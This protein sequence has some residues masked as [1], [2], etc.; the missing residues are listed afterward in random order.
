MKSFQLI[1]ICGLLFGF[2]CQNPEKTNWK[3]ES[4]PFPG[5]LPASLPVLSASEDQLLLSFVSSVN[6]STSALFYSRWENESWSEP[7][8]ITQGQDWFVNWADFPALV[9]NKGNYLAHV[10]KKSSPATFSYDIQLQ[11]FSTADGKWTNQLPLHQDSTLTEHGFVTSIAY[12]DSSYLVTWLDGRNTSGGHDHSNHEAS[13]AMTIRAAEVNLQ[14]KVLWDELLDARTC[15]CCQTTAAMTA[16][17]PIILYRNRSDREIRDIAITR[18]VKGKWTEP[19]IIYP[20]GWEITGCPVNGPKVAAINQTVLAAWFTDVNQESAV[21][22]AFSETSGA[23]FFPP[24]VISIRD[25]LGR[26][27]VALL[28]EQE[29]LVSWMEMAGDSTFLMVQKINRAGDTFP[30]Q[31]VASMDPGRRSGFPQMEIYGNQVFFAWTI[32]GDQPTIG[33]SAVPIDNF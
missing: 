25:A 28:N 10:L 24:Q 13:G 33:I 8:M 1:A 11:A 22:V 19:Q 31:K 7:E 21:K 27:D 15:D 26:V 18:L 32:T 16:E 9:E 30:K 2:S 5:D 29:G 23:D 14:G 3:P 12:S 6:D 20:D 4:I 17:G